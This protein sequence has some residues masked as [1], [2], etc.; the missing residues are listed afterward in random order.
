VEWYNTNIILTPINPCMVVNEETVELTGNEMV[1]KQNIFHN[2][3]KVK[4]I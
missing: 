1:V 4:I 2:T 3:V